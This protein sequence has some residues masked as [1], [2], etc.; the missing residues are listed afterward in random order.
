VETAVRAIAECEPGASACKHERRLLALAFRSAIYNTKYTISRN[1]DIRIAQAFIVWDLEEYQGDDGGDLPLLIRETLG[2][3]V[4]RGG[5]GSFAD[6]P[7]ALFYVS[8]AAF[9]SAARATDR[10]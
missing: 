3:F 9:C 8:R 6:Q 2:R 7:H 1:R 4:E 5:S 10:D